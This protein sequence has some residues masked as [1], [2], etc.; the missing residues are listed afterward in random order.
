MILYDNSIEQFNDDVMLNR[1]ADRA[2]E[3]Y[4]A[5]YK[6]RPATSEY[7]A[8]ANSLAILNNSFI[9]SKLKDNYI[10]VMMGAGDINLQK[11]KLIS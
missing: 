7:R 5:Y 2:A 11:K 1:I 8:W 9:Y 4:E 10:I 3:K 6:R